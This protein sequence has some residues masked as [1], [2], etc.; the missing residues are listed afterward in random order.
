MNAQT[1]ASSYWLQN[2]GTAVMHV[3][4]ESDNVAGSAQPR[5]GRNT[6]GSK[7]LF[8]CN[9]PSSR[10][11][12]IRQSLMPESVFVEQLSV[13]SPAI[14]KPQAIAIIAHAVFRVWRTAISTHWRMSGR[15]LP[16]RFRWNTAS[17]SIRP[18]TSRTST[19][20]LLADRMTDEAPPH[21]RQLYGFAEGQPRKHRAVIAHFGRHP[22]RNAVLGRD[23][24]P[25][26]LEYMAAGDFPHTT[27]LE[28]PTG[29]A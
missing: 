13:R 3:T 14:P 24:T 29:N 7:P 18:T 11:V 6:G 25:E 5:E 19:L 16:T 12:L 1:G 4:G 21:L 8:R 28:S 2:F 15:R 17:V 10:G 27:E 9:E 22:H 23:S 20:I 26:E